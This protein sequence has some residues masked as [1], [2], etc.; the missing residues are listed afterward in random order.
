MKVALLSVDGDI[1]FININKSLASI[2]K[3]LGGYIEPIRL[4][5]TLAERDL[6][7]LVD[8]EGLLRDRPLNPYSWLLG[9]RLVG[10]VLI[11]RHSRSEM[12][13]LR[14]S[15]EEAIRKWLTIAV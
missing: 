12:T 1:E 6:L 5:P 14:A 3:A 4:P 9:Q 13:G 10:T 8:E 11:V 15:D 7:G 2:Q